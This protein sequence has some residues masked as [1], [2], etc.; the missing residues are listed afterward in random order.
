[1]GKWQC[2]HWRV[3]RRRDARPR[4]SY[5]RQWKPARWLLDAWPTSSGNRLR[6][7][8]NSVTLTNADSCFLTNS[9]KRHARIVYEGLVLAYRKHSKKYV[10]EEDKARQAGRGMWAG[11]FVPPWDWRKGKRLKQEEVSTTACCKVCKT[12]KACGDS[13]IS[14][15][16][17][18]SKPKGCACD[19]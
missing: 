18:C 13:C 17:N 8:S 14:K 12:S 16:Y 9:R 5:I 3:E 11:E 10:P 15:S 2:L 4:H 1:M 19:G 7:V 6:R